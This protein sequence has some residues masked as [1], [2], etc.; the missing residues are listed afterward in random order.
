MIIPL[1]VSNSLMMALSYIYIQ[2]IKTSIKSL[3]H[4]KK[5]IHFYSVLYEIN[6]NEA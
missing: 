2:N 6:L 5:L 4:G 3:L 1:K